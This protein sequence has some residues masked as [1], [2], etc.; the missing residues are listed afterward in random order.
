MAQDTSNK[1]LQPASDAAEVV[2]PSPAVLF[3]EQFGIRIG[4]KRYYVNLCIGVEKRSNLRV[5]DE[6]QVSVPGIPVLY[7][8]VGSGLMM[9]FGALCTLYLLKSGAGIDLSEGHSLLHPL[10]ALATGD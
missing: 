4:L 1:A 3:D 5:V 7:C 2:P 6:G 9:I 8:V 10:F